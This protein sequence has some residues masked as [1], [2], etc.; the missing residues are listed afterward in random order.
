MKRLCPLRISNV[1]TILEHIAELV[2]MRTKTIITTTECKR[3]I[4]LL[5]VT[6]L[7]LKVEQ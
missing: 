1:F 5:S 4:G 2:N 7:H 6:F 3:F